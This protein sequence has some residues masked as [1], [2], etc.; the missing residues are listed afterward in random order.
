M[1]TV[2]LFSVCFCYLF[3]TW[4]CTTFNSI[5]I[6][7]NLLFDRNIEK[8]KDCTRSGSFQH[9]IQHR[10]FQLWYLPA[11]ITSVLY[12][13]KIQPII[14]NSYLARFLVTPSKNP[15]SRHCPRKFRFLP[16][17]RVQKK[18]CYQI[19]HGPLIH[20]T[21]KKAKRKQHKNKTAPTRIHE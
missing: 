4:P 9:E 7:L 14:F 19:S 3:W 20:K 10:C 16:S 21:M 8:T 6:I 2:R 15:L 11:L 1:K 5:L 13:A 18:Q 17:T 12:C